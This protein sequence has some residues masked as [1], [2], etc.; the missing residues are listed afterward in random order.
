MSSV[1]TVLIAHDQKH[2]SN[3]KGPWTLNLFK[4][5][6]GNEYKTFE[7]AIA[8]QANALLGQ[9]VTVEYEEKAAKDPKYQPDRILESTVATPGATVA[10]AVPNAAPVAASSIDDRQT[11][12]M[13]Q[14]ALDRALTAFGIAGV[15]PLADLDSVLELSDQ[16]IDYF[17]GGREAVSVVVSV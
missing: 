4:A 8:S 14:S 6:D 17:I 2:G 15:D 1:T 9:T 10:P 16:F 12:I 13:R 3:A 11:M 5:Q 7:N